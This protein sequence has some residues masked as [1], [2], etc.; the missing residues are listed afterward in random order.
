MLQYL[1]Y[2]KKGRIFKMPTVTLVLLIIA[3]RF[4][5]CGDRTLFFGKESRK[6]ESRT[7]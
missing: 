7:G 2:L 3:I 4:D 1:S 5:R 6:K